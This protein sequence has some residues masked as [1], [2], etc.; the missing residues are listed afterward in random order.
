MLDYWEPSSGNLL[1]IAA[2]H[3]QASQ[4][5]VAQTMMIFPNI[6]FGVFLHVVIVGRTSAQAVKLVIG[7]GHLR[8]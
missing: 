1:G 4:I 6:Y 8:Q 3:V 2:V 5:A 7:V